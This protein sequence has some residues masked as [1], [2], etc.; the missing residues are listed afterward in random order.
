M[1]RLQE[2]AALQNLVLAGDVDA[3]SLFAC[4]EVRMIR[5]KLQLGTLCSRTK[6]NGHPLAEQPVIPAR[7]VGDLPRKWGLVRRVLIVKIVYRVKSSGRM[8]TH[9]PHPKAP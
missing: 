7:L 4:Q 8:L 9:N 6:L 5:C 1:R 2:T 3:E